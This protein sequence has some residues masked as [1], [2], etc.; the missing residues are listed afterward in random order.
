[1][2]QSLFRQGNK[3]AFILIP[4]F[5]KG[6]YAVSKEKAGSELT[7]IIEDINKNMKVKEA[8]K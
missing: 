7:N 6:A 5:I 3:N 4:V 2:E 8:V 1:M